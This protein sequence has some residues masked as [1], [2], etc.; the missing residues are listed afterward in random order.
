[1]TEVSAEGSVRSSASRR[2]LTFWSAARVAVSAVGLLALVV[3]G[4]FVL[5]QRD[6][7]LVEKANDQGLAGRYRSA[8]ATAKR[9]G[10]DPYRASAQTVEGYA[11]VALGRPR[12]ALRALSVA[13]ARRPSDWTLHRDRAQ[14]L[15]TLGHRA[16]ARREILRALILNPRME[17]PSGFMRWLAPRVGGASGGDATG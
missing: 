8:V 2:V 6:A 15:L 1:M 4:Y 16:S 10:A 17:L 3:A 13:S 14:L 7:A 11:L 9:V 12:A 5:Q